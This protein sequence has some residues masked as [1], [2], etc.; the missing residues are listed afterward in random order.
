MLSMDDPE[1]MYTVYYFLIMSVLMQSPCAP[2]DTHDGIGWKQFMYKMSKKK[3]E[4][5][6]SLRATLGYISVCM[7]V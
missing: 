4:R 7:S 2:K 5:S 6:K 3:A 1:R